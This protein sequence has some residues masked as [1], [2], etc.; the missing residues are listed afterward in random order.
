MNKNILKHIVRYI[1]MIL[2]IFICSIIFSFSADDGVES[3]TISKR[4]AR[5]IVLMD[6]NN[7]NLSEEELE[8]KIEAIHPIVRKGAHFSIYLVLG[9]SVFGCN[10][11]FKG[12]MYKKTIGS[13][14]FTYFYACTDE[15][16]QRFVARTKL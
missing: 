16:H 8:V 4:V 11:T 14:I 15:L 1:L 3:D 13:I 5:S 7:K 2:I 9:M 12:K 10:L 6:K